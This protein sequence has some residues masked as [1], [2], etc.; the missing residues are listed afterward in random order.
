MQV[1]HAIASFWSD[2]ASSAFC[3]HT[4]LRRATDRIAACHLFTG[5]SMGALLPST[6]RTRNFAGLVW[7]AFRPDAVRMVVAAL[8]L[9]F[10]PCAIDLETGF[11]C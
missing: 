9:G 3:I 1:K 5:K 6:S 10:G 2:K 8:V 7:L 4:S 11:Y